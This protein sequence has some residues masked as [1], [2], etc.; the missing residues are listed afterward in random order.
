MSM[1][2]AEYRHSGVQ[3]LGEIPKHWEG[4]P[5]KRVCQFSS[6]AGFPI[7][8]QGDI[9]QEILFAKVSDMNMVGNERE[10]VSAANTISRDSSRDLGAYIFPPKTII[11]PKV[12]GALLTNK[13][14]LLWEPLSTRNSG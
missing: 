12:G 2:Y 8:A 14:R 6:G 10:I 1:P 5:L 11:F 3:W 13:R 7:S 4:L 9:D